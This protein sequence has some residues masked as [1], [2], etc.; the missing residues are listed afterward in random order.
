M[1][2]PSCVSVCPAAACRKESFLHSSA[3]QCAPLL[4]GAAVHQ[5]RD[6]RD[7]TPGRGGLF[8]STDIP[9]YF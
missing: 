2:K 6:C 1:R 4:L 3:S 9:P 7:R 5:G 8:G